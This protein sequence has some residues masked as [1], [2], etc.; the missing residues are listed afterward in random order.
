M[1]VSTG[2]S[3]TV[4]PVS[5]SHAH[6]SYSNGGTFHATQIE[7]ARATIHFNGTGIAGSCPTLAPT[8]YQIIHPSYRLRL[9]AVHGSRRE[10][11]GTQSFNLKSDSNAFDP[12]AFSVRLDDRITVW[13]GSGDDIFGGAIFTSQELE[14]GEHTLEIWNSA[15]RPDRR[16]AW[17]DI[18]YVGWDKTWSVRTDYLD[19]TCRSLSSLQCRPSAT[20]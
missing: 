12:D 5:R 8:G 1:I 20:R 19:A 7:D 17:L 16:W 11:H 10:N 18:D 4:Q 3:L 2:T 14:E 6:C 9:P 13:N 15:D